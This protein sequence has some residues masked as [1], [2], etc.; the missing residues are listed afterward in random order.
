MQRLTLTDVIKYGY[1]GALLTGL[2]AIVA[3]S[4]VETIIAALGAVATPIVILAI[5]ACVYVMHRYVVGEFVIYPATHAIHWALNRS[6]LRR[7]RVRHV[8]AFLS[9]LGLPFGERRLA[10]TEI[11]R[12]LFKG[13][14]QRRI[15]LSHAEAH[16]LWLTF[17]L[18]LLATS[19]LY[20]YDETRIGVRLALL[21]FSL[22]AGFGGLVLDISLH[23][24]EGRLLEHSL[25]V[26]CVKKFLASRGFRVVGESAS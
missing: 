6:I 26:E 25:G 23:Q 10:Y 21:I 16:V 5:G 8:T 20:I 22:F 9:E 18:G 19:W 14:T 3:P 1:G 12:D 17:V 2:S 4:E 7:A 13:D 24:R 15:D 11:R